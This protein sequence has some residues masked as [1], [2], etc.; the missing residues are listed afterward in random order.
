MI[1]SG[2]EGVLLE[3]PAMSTEG[4]LY[5]TVITI[6]HVEGMKAGKIWTYDP[7]AGEAKVFRSPSGMAK[8]N[9]AF[10]T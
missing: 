4:I 5:F 8:G 6:T 7:Q 1:F 2:G 9:F 3:G 10:T